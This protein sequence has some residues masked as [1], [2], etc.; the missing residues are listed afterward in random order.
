MLTFV[1]MKI[2]NEV[3]IVWELI[4]S[5]EEKITSD[6]TKLAFA[7]IQTWPEVHFVL[8]KGKLAD[9]LCVS[10]IIGRIFYIRGSLSS[11]QVS[12]NCTR[13]STDSDNRLTRIVAN[14]VACL[15]DK[16]HHSQLFTP[17]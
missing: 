3:I 13:C 4:A 11:V 17:N 15:W 8:A 10:G 9:V 1:Y 2:L 16:S 12:K 6:G 5:P 14:D 7:R